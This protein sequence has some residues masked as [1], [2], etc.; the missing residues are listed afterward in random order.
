MYRLL[1]RIQQMKLQHNSDHTFQENEIRSFETLTESGSISGVSSGPKKM[2]DTLLT[3]GPMK[4]VH[5]F[6]KE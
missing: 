2:L 5:K 3:I 4:K 1:I 6:E